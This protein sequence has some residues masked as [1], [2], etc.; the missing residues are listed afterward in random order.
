M[1]PGERRRRGVW[2]RRWVSDEAEVVGSE[3]RGARGVWVCVRECEC[4]FST[5]CVRAWCGRRTTGRGASRPFSPTPPC[6]RAEEERRR[7]GE[8]EERRSSAGGE[9]ERRMRGMGRRGREWGG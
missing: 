6:K 7:R 3:E 2:G 4:V 9:E 5:A 8:E 1:R